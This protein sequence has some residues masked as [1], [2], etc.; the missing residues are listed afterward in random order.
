MRALRFD[1]YG[2]PDVLHVAELPEPTPG[3]GQAKVRVKAVALNPLDAKV[4]SGDLR[5]VPI[6]RGPPRGLG[7]D[8]AGEIVGVGGGAGPRHAG[9]RVFGSLLPFG[10]DGALAQFIVVPFDRLLPIPPEVQ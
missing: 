2:P 5:L 7:C 9:E 6:M 10:R 1:R 8:F 4:R 3:A